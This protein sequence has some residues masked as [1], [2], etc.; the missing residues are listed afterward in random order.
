MSATQKFVVTVNP[1]SQPV[2]SVPVVSSQQASFQI[3]GPAG[4]NYS[5]Q[6]STNLI[7]WST[8]FTT[9]SPALPFTWIDPNGINAPQRYYR[10]QLGP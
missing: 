3:S 2:V 1:V 6:V 9:N 8:V 7:N 10:I 4:F 5:I